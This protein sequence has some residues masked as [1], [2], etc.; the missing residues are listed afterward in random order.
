M[1]RFARADF[2]TAYF[3]DV[4]PNSPTINSSEGK[5]IVALATVSVGAGSPMAR[6]T[7]AHFG[8][9]TPFVPPARDMERRLKDIWE[10]VLDIDGLGVEDDYFELGGESLAAVTMFAELE[11]QFG[12]M[13]PL[14]ILLDCPTIRLLAAHLE[15]L[16][17]K[18]TNSLL[19]AVKG[20]GNRRPLF[21]THAAYGNV[22]Y[23]RRL[24]PFLDGEQPL[25]AIQARGLQEGEIAHR[26]FEAMAKDYCAAIR[27]VQSEGPYILAGHCVG[28]LIAYAMAQH[29]KSQGESVAAVI[30]IDPE[31]HPNGVPWL[32]WRNPSAPQIRLWLQI[33][34]P[35][36]FARLWLRR[37]P[38][39]L[40]GQLPLEPTALNGI[41]RQRREGVREGLRAAL[42]AYRPQPYDGKVF[43][44]CSAERRRLL[45]KPGTGWP[46]LAPEVQFID[47]SASHDE[48]FIAA[49]P[50]VGQALAGVMASLSP[51]GS[52]AL[53]R[54]A[55]E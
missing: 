6:L 49:L 24:A 35:F 16:G 33:L 5:Y 53:N 9:R 8:L 3:L 32:H 21:Y 13:P 34:R 42:R 45:A 27:Q 28:G 47:I 51:Q 19:L 48:F 1:A 29:L 11:T 38:L 43:I 30:M 20:E 40:R 52:Q 17:F 25:H 7:R 23:V 36:W 26:R 46:S 41:Q 39:R 2:L 55:A 54:E 10:A 50:E 18:A 15:K 22:L 44:I 14:S 4:I 31:Y 12:E 37:L